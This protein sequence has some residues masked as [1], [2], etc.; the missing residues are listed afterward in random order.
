VQDCVVLDNSTD[1]GARN[2]RKITACVIDQNANFEV[3]HGLLDLIM[4]KVGAGFG[5]HY[6]L[7][8]D[9]ADPRF[10]PTRGLRVLLNGS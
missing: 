9:T 1:T 6:K 2:I 3:I 4:L 8:L 10:F 5:K 7:E